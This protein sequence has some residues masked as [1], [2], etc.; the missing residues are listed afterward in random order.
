MFIRIVP[1]IW[2]IRHES[3]QNLGIPD[4]VCLRLFI[5]RKDLHDKLIIRTPSEQEELGENMEEEGL[6]A[7]GR[8][9]ML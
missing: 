7:H 1:W 6:Y 3:E 4:L 9:A 2:R 8:L 5:D